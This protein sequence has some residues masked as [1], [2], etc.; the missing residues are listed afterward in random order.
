MPWAL[1]MS[2]R[3]P[4]GVFWRIADLAVF[5]PLAPPSPPPPPNF[6]P[7]VIL[8]TPG[9][10]NF[11]EMLARSGGMMEY[12]TGKDGRAGDTPNSFSVFAPSNAAFAA[13][14]TK[15]MEWMLDPAK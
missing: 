6:A 10:S 12:L 4:A 15:W 14:P 3:A 9:L 11:A 7:Q 1:E 5:L 8:Q 13:L 2:G